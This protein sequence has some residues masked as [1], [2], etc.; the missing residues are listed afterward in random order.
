MSI[1]TTNSVAKGLLIARSKTPA[2]K[3]HSVLACQRTNEGRPVVFSAGQRR[4]LTCNT[5]PAQ[6][7][8]LALQPA[9]AAAA[10]ALPE[11]WH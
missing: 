2:G 10:L 8:A 1:A 4:S 11:I 5:K 7:F 3:L 6:S 9:M